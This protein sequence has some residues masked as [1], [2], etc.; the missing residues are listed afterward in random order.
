MINW[1]VRIKNKNW[2][3]SIIPAI[4]LLVQSLARVFGYELHIDGISARLIDVINAAFTVL[5]LVG[6][7]VDPTTAGLGDSQLAMTYDKPK[8]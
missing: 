5:A 8:E 6:V 3:I 7:T 1:I 4:L 2:W